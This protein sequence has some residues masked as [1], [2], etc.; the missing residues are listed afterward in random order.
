VSDPSI[1]RLNE[2]LKGVSSVFFNLG[3][4]TIGAAA[5]RFALNGFVDW[6]GIGWLF[7]ALV[8]IWLGA[9][10]LGLMEAEV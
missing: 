7:G 9:K 4:A 5:A 1:I 8:L 2:Q 3:T 10:V 6:V